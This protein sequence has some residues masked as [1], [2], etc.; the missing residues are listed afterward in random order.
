MITNFG[1]ILL[2]SEVD[3]LRPNRR[4]HHRVILQC[5]ILCR[6]AGRCSP[7]TAALILLRKIRIDTEP[8]RSIIHAIIHLKAKIIITITRSA[9]TDYIE[10][11]TVLSE[12]NQA[13]NHNVGTWEKQNSTE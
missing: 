11:L 9:I 7:S 1:N 3:T 10:K 13:G 5:G 4:H 2:P 8:R 12:V 6:H